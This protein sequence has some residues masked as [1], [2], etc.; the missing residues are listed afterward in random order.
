MLNLNP[1]MVQEVVEVLHIAR[2]AALH[3]AKVALTCVPAGRG[4]SFAELD[5]WA[6]RAAHAYRTCGLRQGDCVAIRLPNTV[7]MVVAI[8][9][10][11]RAGLYYTLIPTKASDADTD[12]IV[13]DS[14]SRLLLVASAFD[15]AC[16]TSDYRVMTS[17]GW[18]DGA[19]EWEALL[20]EQP[21]ALLADPAPGT[22]MIY[23]SGTT[24]RPKGVRKKP[25]A[26]HWDSPDPRNVD[27][28]RGIGLGS[29]GVFLATSP[30]YHSAPHRYLCAA[31]HCGAHV[32]LMEQFDAAE[33]LAHIERYQCTHSL[34]VPTMF[35]RLLKLD[36]AL[37]QAYA[38]ESM[39]IA[40]HGAAPCPL[41]VK[42]AMIDWWGP[43]LV[44]Y[45]SGTEGIG[46][47]VITS[48]EWLAHPGSVGKP[49]DCVAHILDDAY[50]EVPARSVGTVYFESK[51]AF[52][53]WR[54]PAKTKSSASPQGWFTFGDV[55]YLDE[56]G[57]LYLTDRKGFMVISGGVNI[58][59]QEIE[60]TLLADPDVLDIA[61][62]GVPDDDLGER[63]VAIVQVVN[64]DRGNAAKALALL[65]HCKAT[66]GGIK[67]PKLV[68]FTTEFPR[69]ENGKVQKN[70]LRQ[71][72]IAGELR[73][74][75]RFERAQLL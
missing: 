60:N 25:V 63:L 27:A 17:S 2:M 20:L 69:Q 26:E 45:Y 33:C 54:D 71:Q 34:W 47:T 41:H 9:A 51:T 56:D 6:N 7:A 40:I 1:P 21:T 18:L 65:Q 48:Q 55:G 24:G 15:A 30:L 12:Y 23:T 68:A 53:Y 49:R 37:R 64:I 13:T 8:L 29:S 39:Q 32:V 44:E 38:G 5:A 10:A 72:F 46:R 75:A 22:E 36:P 42:Q 31:L 43:I 3:P 73:D 52:S 16:Q 74:L 59:P 62:F 66:L 4:Y 19:A 11:Q 35:Q 50:A 14:Q 58:Y 28:A 57:Y 67:T 61:V 70:A